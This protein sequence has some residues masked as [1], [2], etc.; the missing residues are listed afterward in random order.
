MLYIEH[1]SL[2]SVLETKKKE[3][4]SQA[5]N[6]QIFFIMSINQEYTWRFVVSG[7]PYGPLFLFILTLRHLHQTS[8]V[9]GHTTNIQMREMI[10]ALDLGI[11]SHGDGIQPILP[12]SWSYIIS[13]SCIVMS[14]KQNIHWKQKHFTEIYAWTL[15]VWIEHSMSEL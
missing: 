3:R 14:A 10:T 12:F 8:T 7:L 11:L 6:I 9:A 13:W 5:W 15:Y 2:I 4:K 1:W